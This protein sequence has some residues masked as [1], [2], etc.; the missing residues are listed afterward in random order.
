MRHR[1]IL[2]LLATASVFASCKEETFDDPFNGFDSYITA[3]SLQQGETVFHAAISGDLITVTAPEGLSLSNAKATVKLSENATIYPDPSKITDWESEHIFVVTAYNSGQIKYKYTIERNGIAHDG[4]VI[5]ETQ[6]DVDAFGQ[7]GITFIDGNLTIGRATG[8]D[9]I[10]SLA[11]LASLKEVAYSLTVQP[12][13]AITGL[14]GLESLER[15]GNVLKFGELKYL[16][17]LSLPAL[18]TA[19]TLD[20]QNTVTIIIELPELTRVPKLI[21]LYC[22]LYQLQLPRLEYTETLTLSTSSNSGASLAKISLP[23]LE[24]VGNMSFGYFKSV[25]KIEFPALKKSGGLMCTQMTLLSFIYAPVWEEIMGEIRLISTSMV[26]F[27]LPELKYVKSIYLDSPGLKIVEFPKLTQAGSI[28]MYNLTMDGFTALQTV[29]GIVLNS[30]KTDGILKFPASIKNIGNLSIGIYVTSYTLQEINVKGININN[31]QIQQYAMPAKLVGDDVFHGTLSFNPTSSGNNVKF[32]QLEG[33]SEIDS[34][35]MTPNNMDTIHIAGIRK[36]N[37][38]FRIQSGYYGYPTLFK[39]SDL[40]ETGGDFIINLPSMTKFDTETI[41]FDKL[42]SVG[43]NFIFTVGTKGAK[44][45][46]F[47]ELTNIAGDF[48]L[49]SGY[50]NAGFRGFESLDFPK[51]TDIGGKLT[52]HSGNTNQNNSQLKNLNGFSA[53]R[54]V[55][56]IEITRQAELVSYEGLKEAFKSL[57]SPDDWKTGNNAYNPSYEDLQADKWNND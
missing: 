46:T 10:T 40:E 41:S 27:G 3:F 21:N 7:Q 47:P 31:L 48:N 28:N 42:K 1:F 50:D 13:C 36:V 38:G 19:G 9:S 53:L 30:P 57:A 49:S 29:E 4:T 18:K 24:E 14:E 15:V 12:T 34:L 37:K 17:I 33:F 6:A 11:P 43:G 23:A 16:E 5:L 44:N 26:E 22:P 8:T 32:P 45:L 35:Y 39:I 25:A 20:V 51:L 55:K 56:A 54:N 2:L 52:V